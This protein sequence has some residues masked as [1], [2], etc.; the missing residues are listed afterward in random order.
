VIRDHLRQLLN[1]QLVIAATG[2]DFAF[3]HALT[4][5][6]VYATILRRE[7]RAAHLAVGETL[8]ALFAGT[9]DEHL[10]DLAHHYYQAG[11]WD[12]ALAF[13]RLAGQQAQRDY[14]PHEAHQHYTR[15][16]EAAQ[17]LAG[18]RHGPPDL[19]RARG[20]VHEIMGDFDGA[21]DDYE[22]A[23]EAA[24]A[25]GDARAEWQI[26]LD[27]GLLWA[28]RDYELA[29]DYLRRALDLARSLDDPDTLGHSLNRVGNWHLNRDEMQTA[30]TYHQ[31][32]LVLFERGSNRRGLAETLDLMGLTLSNIGDLRRSRTVY[33]R[34]LAILRELDD[35]RGQASS[36]AIMAEHAPSFASDVAVPAISLAQARAEAEQS[37]R[38][39]RAIGWRAGEAFALLIHAG[40][41]LAGGYFGA[42][43][44]EAEVGRA[45]AFEIGHHQWLTLAH[46][47]FGCYHAE[48]LALDEARRSL[49]EASALAR[50]VNSIL[51]ER[52]SA[53]QL[54]AI[55]VAQGDLAA[56]EAA[57]AGQPP[58]EST[59]STV[60][61]RLVALAQAELR[62]ARGDAAGALELGGRVAAATPYVAEGGVVPRLWLLRGQCLTA[63][64]R[65]AE[66]A[67]DLR[68]G[69]AAAREQRPLL[70]RLTAA[71]AQAYAAQGEAA[72][73]EH[74]TAAARDLVLAL[75][76]S[77]PNPAQRER[78]TR[79][80][81]TRLAA[82]SALA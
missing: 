51:W 45:V 66:A 56:A 39:A 6:A 57:L 49:A 14:A 48:L 4:R 3:R 69:Q 63:L 65:Y 44:R 13:A 80:A 37:L 38:L 43:L 73:A 47:W 31:E 58:A 17:M 35:R 23:L 64:G 60:P 61:Q 79:A 32:A 76:A 27:Q 67:T 55:C 2:E 53:G 70:W 68:A 10:A 52:I 40:L 71:L 41:W 46:V 42:A 24:R 11:A 74:E 82:P 34:A 50:Q 9:P 5:E 15:A 8:E 29:G 77:V 19:Y 30:L 81:L 12:K 21:R 16:L 62:L 1:S 59:P 22:A 33:T 18:G 25:A 20:Q 54:A 28:G 75:A 26:L 72:A 36:L 7:R 78:F